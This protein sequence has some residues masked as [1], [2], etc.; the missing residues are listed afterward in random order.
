MRERGSQ[1]GSYT[2]EGIVSIGVFFVLLALIVQIGFLILSRSTAASTVESGLRRAVAGDLDPGT[3]ENRIERDLLL[4]V[5]GAEG[6]NVDV[7]SGRETIH[8]LV[9]YRWIPPGPDL[10]PVTVSIERSAVRAVPP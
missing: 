4:V 8:A 7:T 9:R 10:L 1:E 6:V 5:P 3:V 2:V